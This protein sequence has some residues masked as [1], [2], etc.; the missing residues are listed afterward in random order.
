MDLAREVRAE[1]KDARAREKKLIAD[2]ALLEEAFVPWSDVQENLPPYERVAQ[3]NVFLASRAQ[4]NSKK[5]RLVAVRR[6]I[7]GLEEELAEI[8]ADASGHP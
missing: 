8:K 3:Y 5:L 4:I 2:L 1:L 6:L 7:Q